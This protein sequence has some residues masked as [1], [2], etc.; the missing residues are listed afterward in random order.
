MLVAPFIKPG[1]SDEPTGFELRPYQREAVEAAIK[2]FNEFDRQLIVCPTGGGKTLLFAKIAEHYQ[3][4]RTLV[5]AHREELLEQARDKILRATGIVAEIEAAER[6]A[7]LDA[8]VVVASVQTLMREYRRRRFAPDHFALI[9]VDEAHHTLAESYQRVLGYFED[10]CVLGVTATPDRGDKRLLADYFENVAHET[11]LVDLIRDGYL[12]RI[13]AKTIPLKIDLRDVHTVA[14]DFNADEVGHALEPHL[15]AIADIIARDFA[16]C[17]SL[18]FLPLCALSERFA[19]LCR[20]RGIAAEHVDGESKDR[21]SVLERFRSGETSLVSNAML[22]SEGFDEPSIDCV[23]PLRPTKIRSLYAQQV[24]RGTRLHPGKDFLSV[25][26]FLWLT[27][28]HNLIRPVALIAQDEE[29]AQTMGGDGDLLDR[30]EEYRQKRFARL[31]EEL[32]ANKRRKTKEFDLLEFAVAIGDAELASFEPT[33]RWHEDPITPR[34][35]E[36]LARCGI[37]PAMLQGKGHACHVIDRIMQRR[38]AG[39]ATYKQ[40]RTLRKFGVPEAHLISFNRASAILDRL[41]SNRGTS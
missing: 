14:G 9:V 18:A 11:T 30:A 10:A 5:L 24:G 8:P 4:R 2:G 23:I 36:F 28:R 21:A 1:R 39:L 34:Q 27:H 15:A 7:S 20:N 33:M 37:N 3:P 19:E 41:F 31:P 40:V 16:G 22:W 35:A 25:L 12:C 38:A 29:E 17:K 26:D 13:R 6:T 32:E